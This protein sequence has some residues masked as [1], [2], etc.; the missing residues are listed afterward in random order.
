MLQ[1][2]CDCVKLVWGR[3]YY[4]KVWQTPVTAICGPAPASGMLCWAQFLQVSVSNVSAIQKQ[5]CPEVWPCAPH[6]V[7]GCVYGSRGPSDG[8]ALRSPARTLFCY[9]CHAIGSRGLN[10]GKA[11][12]LRQLALCTPK[13]SVY[14][15]C[16]ATASRG[17]SA[18]MID[19]IRSHDQLWCDVWDVM[20]MQYILWCDEWVINGYDEFCVKGGAVVGC[21]FCFSHTIYL[22]IYLSSYLSTYL[23]T[24]Q[25]TYLPT[26][27]SIYLPT[28]LPIFLS[29]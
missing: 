21:G 27:L 1:I 12:Q 26:Y 2:L 19:E 7:G 17:W 29:F 18:N 23:P 20:N 25:P 5:Q 16:D 6:P 11:P 3:K 14:W 24:Y 28:Y 10:G 22:S 4:K 13:A 9:T 8:H 15:T